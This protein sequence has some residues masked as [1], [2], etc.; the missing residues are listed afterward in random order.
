[1][2]TDISTGWKYAE[3]AVSDAVGIPESATDVDLPVDLLRYKNRNYHAALGAYGSYYDAVSAVFFRYLPRLQ[4]CARIVLEIEGVCGFADVR[5]NGAVVAHITGGG[6]H[7]VDISDTYAFGTTNL[8]A[9][10]VTA[11]Q[12][13]GKY[14]GAGICGGVRLHTHAQPL[15]VKEDGV[16]VTTRLESGKA[17]VSV[18]AEIGDGTGEACAAR[19]T[20]T[21]EA[22]LKNARGKKTARKVKKYKLKNTYVNTCEIPFKIKRYYTWTVED[23]YLYSVC[24]T[25]TDETGAVLDSAEAPFGIVSRQLSPSRGLVLCGRSVTLKGAVVQPDNG[26]LG[27]ESTFAVEEYKLRRIKEIGYNAVRYP[28]VPCEAALD[29]LDAVGLMAEVDLF[30]TWGQGR[31]PYDGHAEFAASWAND[32]E[33]F[34]CQ[35]R[36]HPSVVLYGLND[37]AEETYERGEGSRTAAMLADAVRSIDDSRPIVVNACERV[38]LKRELEQAGIK[39]AKIDDE[40]AAVSAGREKDL[41]GTLTEASFACADIAGYAY[42]YPRYASDR[43]DRPDRLIVGTA[44]YASRA[45]EAFEECEKNSNVVGEFLYCAADY[46]GY[47]LGKQTF[48][49]EQLKLLPPHTSLCGDLDLIYNRKPAAYYRSIML[50][51]RAQSCIAVSDPEAEGEPE[52][53]GHAV[54]RVHNLWNWPHSLGKPIAIEVYSGGEVVA[55]YRD[56]KLIGRRLAGKVNKHVATFKTDYYPGTLEAVSYHKGRE[57]SR[58]QLESVTSPRAV[59]LSCDRK[60][61]GAGELILVEIAVTDKEGRVVPYAA[62]E[63]ELTVSGD[64]ELYAL[65]SADPESQTR[66]G[67]SSV[68]PVYEGRALAAIKTKAGGEGK[69]AV[70]ATGDGLLSG[71]ITLK[72]K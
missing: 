20:V 7:Y 44:S 48:N 10:C 3:G 41:F 66:T 5:L 34:V 38:P 2:F 71:K 63:V 23:P 37:D 32:C 31:F 49:G 18:H 24:V 70:R 15:F 50:G 9:L 35:L 28:S 56:G 39:T 54:R 25:L 17:L 45:F 51:N 47:P 27:A 58:V 26:I 14:T 68:C 29:A 57:C 53:A 6:K 22:V 13:A 61:R 46:L 55:L 42:L 30:G 72:V 60:S 65:G 64:G 19:K 4:K 69:I 8:L 11:P 59:K 1:M 36:K 67:G 21:V 43:T 16:F 40:A 62:R 12:M 33:R 52:K